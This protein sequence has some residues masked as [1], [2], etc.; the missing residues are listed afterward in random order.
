MSK[1]T[2]IVVIL[3]IFILEIALMFFDRG[4]SFITTVGMLIL[5]VPDTIISFIR[6]D[7]L[8]WA[9]FAT[10]MLY[11]LLIVVHLMIQ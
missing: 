8:R 9:N 10:I 6:R 1:K 7:E 5:C 4:L 2:I 11:A 3:V